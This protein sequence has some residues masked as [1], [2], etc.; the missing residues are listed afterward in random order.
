MSAPTW[1]KLLDT[2]V[3]ILVRAAG[4]DEAR[5]R[6]GAR[7]GRETIAG[8][9]HQVEP[10]N[11]PEPPYGRAGDYPQRNGDCAANNPHTSRYHGE[12]LKVFTTSL[13]YEFS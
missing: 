7:R 12:A 10:G 9:R 1:E 13:I 5:W 3:Q 4:G 11:Q 8:V 2:L 6:E